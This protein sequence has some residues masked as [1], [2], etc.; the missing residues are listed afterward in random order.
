MFRKREYLIKRAKELNIVD[1]IRI[2]GPVSEKQKL[3]LFSSADIFV[4]PTLYEGFGI[5]I[6][7]AM[8]F[9]LPVISTNIPVI[10]EI[11]TEDVGLL[12]KPKDP[13]ALADAIS[14]L[15]SEDE[16]HLRNMGA[17]AQLL[18]RDKYN[19]RSIAKEYLSI[20]HE[21]LAK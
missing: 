4:F 10:N 11:V 21:V 13:I 9:G 2:E 1:K 16:D 3:I 12:V 8:V 6:I 15:L 14:K 20:Y 5:P 17:K 19:W 7:E 18:V